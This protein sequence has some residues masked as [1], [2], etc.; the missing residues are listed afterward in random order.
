MIVYI[1]NSGR[2]RDRVS[3]RLSERVRFESLLV[4]KKARYKSCLLLLCLLFAGTT[5]LEIEK[6]VFMS[7]V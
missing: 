7:A 6:K 4:V 5:I 3:E 1:V 2:M